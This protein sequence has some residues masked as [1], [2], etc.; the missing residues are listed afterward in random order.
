MKTIVVKRYPTLYKGSTLRN[1]PIATADLSSGV[2]IS[3]LHLDEGAID[4][5]KWRI[6][7]TI[8]YLSGSR[9][10]PR[11]QIRIQIT[12]AYSLNKG[13]YWRRQSLHTY[14]S[15]NG[16]FKRRT[17]QTHHALNS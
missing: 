15:R 14:A 16:R 10:L 17:T 9:L 6:N 1:T 4:S 3:A 5:T 7:G 13:S 12:F 8:M 2:Q 11:Q